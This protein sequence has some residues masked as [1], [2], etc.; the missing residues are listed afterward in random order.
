M[1]DNNI[2]YIVTC[3]ASTK[4]NKIYRTT[5]GWATYTAK[6]DILPVTSGTAAYTG[7]VVLGNIAFV[8]TF[9]PDTVIITG[10]NNAYYHVSNDG[11]TTWN[12][13]TPA[14]APNKIYRMHF[15]TS[16]S[17]IAITTLTNSS[18]GGVYLN[19]QGGTGAPQTIKEFSVKDIQ[20]NLVIYPNPGKRG[21]KITVRDLEQGAQVNIIDINGRTVQTLTSET[22]SFTVENL[23]PGLYFVQ[24]N[25]KNKPART[26]KLIIQ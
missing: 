2:G 3:E 1:V 13:V 24:V 23:L 5:D 19:T 16:S 26:A 7:N 8:H 17:Y 15:F 4:K 21:E 20:N 25:E 18:P 6:T 12:T 14:F 22:E 11:G 9:G 10:N